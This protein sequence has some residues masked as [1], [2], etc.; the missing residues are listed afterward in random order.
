MKQDRLLTE[1]EYLDAFKAYYSC[2]AV[3]I[4]KVSLRDFVVKLQ[5]AKSV[6]LNNKEWIEWLGKYSLI[7]PVDPRYKAFRMNLWEW[8]ALEE[9]V[10]G[11][12]DG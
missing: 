11:V 6:H 5:D 9:K 7:D 12:K 10:D 8:Q 3:D 2:K 1:E 4:T